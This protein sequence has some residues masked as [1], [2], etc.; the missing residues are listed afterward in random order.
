MT[1]TEFKNGTKNSYIHSQGSELVIEGSRFK[2]G[3]EVDVNVQ[4]R[5]IYC[6]QCT[7]L[8]VTGTSFTNLTAF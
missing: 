3:K 4:G 8:N 2:Q 1:N 7:Q 5:A 6:D